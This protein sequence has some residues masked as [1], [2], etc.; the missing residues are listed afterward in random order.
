MAVDDAY[1]PGEYKTILQLV[2]VLS[3]GK[4]GVQLHLIRLTEQRRR[5]SPTRSSITWKA[6]KICV[7]PSTST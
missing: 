6:F 2:T 1:R 5:E 4:G 3:H 7:K